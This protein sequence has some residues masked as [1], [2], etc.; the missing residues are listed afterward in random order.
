MPDIVDADINHY[1]RGIVGQ[2]IAIEAF[3]QIGHLMPAYARADHLDRAAGVSFRQ[4]FRHQCDISSRK[5]PHFGNGVPE[6]NNAYGRGRLRIGSFRSVFLSGAA[7]GQDQGEKGRK[8]CCSVNR[9]THETMVC[10]Q[11]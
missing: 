4:G 3:L 1:M 9:I 2:H 8:E 6:E 11:K 5:D 10:L 7:A